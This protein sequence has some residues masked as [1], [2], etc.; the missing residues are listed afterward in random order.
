MQVACEYASIIKSRT[1]RANRQNEVSGVNASVLRV[2]ISAVHT[3]FFT[4]LF[5]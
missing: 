1:V 2:L 3:G 4:H 5:I